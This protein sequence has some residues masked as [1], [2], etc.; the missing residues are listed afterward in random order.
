MKQELRY[1]ISVKLNNNAILVYHFVTDYSLQDGALIFTDS[2]TGKIKIFILRFLL[3]CN[4][5]VE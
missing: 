1:K 4:I 3:D 5:E 2:K